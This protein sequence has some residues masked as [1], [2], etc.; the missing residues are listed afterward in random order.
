MGEFDQDRASHDAGTRK[1]EELGGDEPGRPSDAS[2]PDHQSP[3]RTARDATG[4]NP[5]AEEPID[6][7]MPEMPPA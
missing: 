6:P 5:E 3:G 2:H 1:G 4:V 7:A